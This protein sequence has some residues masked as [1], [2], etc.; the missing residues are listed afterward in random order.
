MLKVIVSSKQQIPSNIRVRTRQAGGT[1]DAN[2]QV[3]HQPDSLAYSNPFITHS[4][5]SD[6]AYRF[7][8][9]LSISSGFSTCNGV[10]QSSTTFHV[11]VMNGL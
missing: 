1:V 11:L 6:A 2:I 4:G 9:F 5:A 8:A 7:A 3:G 10:I